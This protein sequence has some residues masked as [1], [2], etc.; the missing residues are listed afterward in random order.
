MK[1]RFSRLAVIA[2]L[3]ACAALLPVTAWAVSAPG[4]PRG[5]EVAARVVFWEWDWVA[6]AAQYE[7]SV[8]GIVVTTTSNHHYY[9][10]DLW[11]GDHSMSVKAIDS[12][13]Q[14][15][16]RSATA[17]I[18][19]DGNFDASNPRSSYIVGAG[20]NNSTATASPSSPT[21]TG[22]T[23]TGTTTRTESGTAAA[24]P[25]NPRGAEVAY[26]TVKWEWD[27]V[28]GAAQYEV[29][30]DGKVAAL[31]SDT[32]YFSR[33]L[34]VGDHSLTVKSI[35]ADGIRS[36]MSATAKI[37]TTSSGSGATSYI[38]GQGSP[39]TSTTTVTP[40]ASPAPVQQDAPVADTGL[41]DPASWG[42][43]EVYQ[44]DGYELAFSDEFNGWSVNPARWHTQLR[45]DGEWNGER[46][47]YRVI[48]GED[49]LYVSPL[50]PDQ[51]HRDQVASVYNPFEFNGNRLAIRAKRNPMQ[52]NNGN[53]NHGSL[54]QIMAQQTFLS[55]AMAT[56][57][58]FYQKYGI[59]EARIK[60]PSHVGTFPAF[61]LYHQKRKTEG[62]RRTEIDIMENLGHAPWYIYNTAHYFTNVT[63]TYGGDDHFLR[64]QPNGQ[65][66]TGTDYSQ[67][68]H[69]Y[70]VEWTPG[71]VVW[72]ID[73]NKV[74]EL[75]HGAVD[76]EELYVIINMALGGNWTNFPANSGGLGRPFSEYFPNANDLANFQNPALEIDYVRV[77]RPK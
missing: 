9:S 16:A 22:T 37:K 62:T 11:S 71:H 48:N 33:D 25:T 66:Y 43:P 50:S 34:W 41:I 52:Q 3:L 12:G 73:G 46:Y 21:T 13:G 47:E 15:S 59:F 35:T 67:D 8:D 4:N 26:G 18:N 10:R 56:Y 60:I 69:V 75:W 70:S 2:S 24:V 39:S 61:W 55:G 32:S 53:L 14:H 29:K 64:P 63:P 45:W 5:K 77:Y 40:A 51:A 38:V 20:G 68:Y 23:T 57:D 27:W 7:V 42:Y 36:G 30:V 72:K 74:S 17:K 54:S 44:K 6:G 76:Y 28:S 49:Q 1:N 31:V 65:I 19:I 58:K